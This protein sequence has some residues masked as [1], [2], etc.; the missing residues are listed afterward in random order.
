MIKLRKNHKK[1]LNDE[2]NKLWKPFWSSWTWN[3]EQLPP[4]PP[5]QSPPQAPLLL[6]IVAS[7]HCAFIRL[8]IEWARQSITTKACNA[9]WLPFN[10]V[11]AC[12][13]M[14]IYQLVGCY[15]PAIGARPWCGH[16]LT[17]STVTTHLKTCYSQIVKTVVDGD[18]GIHLICILIN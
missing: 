2:E 9:D 12:D 7:N 16:Y 8:S 14:R 18:A 15:A 4:P 10:S 6:L 13:F 17:V 3:G 5:P 1:K 11:Y